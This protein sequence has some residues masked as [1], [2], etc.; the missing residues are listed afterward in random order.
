LVG[1][2]QAARLLYSALKIDA[3]EAL[4]IGLVDLVE[5]DMAVTIEAIA[6]NEAA[7]L[8]LLKR[9]IRAAGQGK[10]QDDSLDRGFDELMAGESLAIRLKALG[11]G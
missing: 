10:S 5:D 3:S 6:A 1:T 11:R 7:S 9:S 4:R 2:G 8:K